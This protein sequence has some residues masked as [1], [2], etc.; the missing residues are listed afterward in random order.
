VDVELWYSPSEETGIRF[1]VDFEPYY[2]NLKNYIHFLPKFVVWQCEDCDSAKVSDD[3][4]FNGK[5][6]ALDPDGAGP[7]KGVAIIQETLRGVC[8]AKLDI[9]IFLDY[10]G[11]WNK[12]CLH[13]DMDFSENCSYHQMMEI[14]KKNK[15]IINELSNCIEDSRV[16]EDGQEV[17]NSILSHAVY[18][19]EQVGIMLFPSLTINNFTFIGNLDALE[20]TD[21]ICSALPNYPNQC[22]LIET[23][24]NQ[25]H[26][27]FY[28]SLIV[29]L[30][31]FFIIAISLIFYCRARIREQMSREMKFQVSTLVSQYIVLQEKKSQTNVALDD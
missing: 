16:F 20:V 2:K 5:Y 7:F 12:N 10:V 30:A 11:L 17:D 13:Q 9:T 6:C 27:F 8:L 19:M 26:Y 3:C 4:L 23:G 25:T 31:S 21:G 14:D 24:K 29:I 15:A 28:M 18:E 1:L 22:H